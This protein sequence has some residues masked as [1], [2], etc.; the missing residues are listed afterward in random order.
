MIGGGPEYLDAVITYE[1]NVILMNRKHGQ[2]LR[3][4]LAAVYPQ[5]GTVVVG[6]PFAILDAAPWVTPEQVAAAKVFGT[7]LLSKEQQEAV[8]GIGLRPAD[9]GVKLTSPIDASMGAN[10]EAKFATLE[11]PETRVIEHLGEVWR[12]VK[13]HAAIVVL[14]DKSG[15]MSD[16]GKIGAAVKG[17]QEFVR[18]MEGEDLLIWMPFDGIIYPINVSGLKSQIGEELVQQIAGTRAQGG[19]ALYDAIL[20]A[21]D[22]LAGLRPKYKNTVRYGIVLLSDGRDESSSNTLST[23]AEK[24]RPQENDPTGVQIHAIAIGS[25]ADEKVLRRIAGAAHGR[26]WK[27]QTARDM[28]RIYKEIATYW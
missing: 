28:V 25:D 14:F 22:H 4:P 8:M 10:P 16:G 17:A 26:Y 27:G 3:E 7:F 12:R 6:H 24:L 23:L 5:D 11:V 21:M 13:K 19:T 15:S 20:A 18:Q 2:S 1:S 9:P